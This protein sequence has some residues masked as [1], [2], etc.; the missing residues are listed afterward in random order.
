M[1]HHLP[2]SGEHVYGIAESSQARS[3][4]KGW[5]AGGAAGH[6]LGT[7]DAIAAPSWC[8][9][10]LRVV[11]EGVCQWMPGSVG[12]RVRICVCPC[13]PPWREPSGHSPP[14]ASAVPPALHSQPSRAGCGYLVLLEPSLL[15][16]KYRLVAARG[17]ALPQRRG[18]PGPGCSLRCAPCRAV[19]RSAPALS[20]ALRCA[21]SREALSILQSHCHSSR[22]ARRAANANAGQCFY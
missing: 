22:R 19:S 21:A 5:G 14:T 11:T 7:G 3:V 16:D 9:T 18:S 1:A 10:Q 8:V 17:Q 13:P 6:S 20:D 4:G 2:V 15:W 12:T